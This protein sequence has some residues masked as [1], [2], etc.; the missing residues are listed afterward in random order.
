MDGTGTA[1]AN[2][3]AKCVTNTRCLGVTVPYSA[4]RW[5]A[6]PKGVKIASLG[7]WR[8]PVTPGGKAWMEG[9]GFRQLQYWYCLC[10]WK[11]PTGTG[12]NTPLTHPCDIGYICLCV[13]SGFMIKQV[14]MV[15]PAGCI[16]R[17]GCLGRVLD[18]K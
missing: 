1:L 7:R 9:P 2:Q 14:L 11:H 6:T 4:C 12:R 15:Q 3:E 18:S 13:C 17:I 10:G 8:D 16:C 5:E